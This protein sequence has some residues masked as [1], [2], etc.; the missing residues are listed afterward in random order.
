MQASHTETEK[1]QSKPSTNEEEEL[2]SLTQQ[3]Q[4]QQQKAVASNDQFIAAGN[5]SRDFV[6]ALGA[7]NIDDIIEEEEEEEDELSVAATKAD[8]RVLQNQLSNVEEEELPAEESSKVVVVGENT[9][10]TLEPVVLDVIEGSP[11]AKKEEAITEQVND[12]VAEGS[13]HEDTDNS[14]TGSNEIRV[15]EGYA[16]R[17]MD[18]FFRQTIAQIKEELTKKLENNNPDEDEDI[19]D[20]SDEEESEDDDEYDED[21]DEDDV[22]NQR[23]NID[24]CNSSKAASK[25]NRMVLYQ[26]LLSANRSSKPSAKMSCGLKETAATWMVLAGCIINMIIVEGLTFNYPNFFGFVEREWDVRSKLVASLPTVF[27]LAVFLL[28]TPFAVFLAKVHGSRKVAV[29]GSAVSTV[30]LVLCSFQDNIVGF[31]VTYGCLNGK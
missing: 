25:P 7:S 1:S 23:L 9:K 22:E 20:F 10:F 11:V 4:P 8:N 30:A 12:D 18:E 6:S 5:I 13:N 17:Q 31:A 2:T 27:L 16:T 21:E 19:G 14:A 29:V 28:G 15:E 3:V 24:A 26:Q